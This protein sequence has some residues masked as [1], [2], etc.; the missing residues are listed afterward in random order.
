MHQRIEKYAV[1][2]QIVLLCGVNIVRRARARIGD[3]GVENTANRARVPFGAKQLYNLCRRQNLMVVPLHPFTGILLVGPAQRIEI[4]AGLYHDRFIEGKPAGD[5]T[6]VA[7][8]D[9]FRIADKQLDNL[10]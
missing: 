7:F 1:I 10:L 8:K 4:N 2:E 6:V 3:F 9:F 5:F